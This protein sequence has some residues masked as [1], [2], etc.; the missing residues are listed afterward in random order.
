MAGLQRA[1]RR[2]NEFADVFEDEFDDDF[3]DTLPAPRRAPEQDNSPGT[4]PVSAVRPRI[5]TGPRGRT[6]IRRRPTDRATFWRVLAVSAAVLVVG[7][8]GLLA[9]HAMR[10]GTSADIPPQAATDDSAPAQLA[11]TAP[12]DA[13]RTVTAAA[14]PQAGDLQ[15]SARVAKVASI[16]TAPAVPAP[17]AE[18]PPQKALALTAAPAVPPAATEAGPTAAD[19]ARPAFIEPVTEDDEADMPDAATAPLPQP[20]PTQLASAEDATPRDADA[21]SARITM[22]VTLRSGPRRSAS[23]IGTLNEGTKVALYSCKSWC[24][25]SSGDKRGF[26]YRNAVGR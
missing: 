14:I 17:P 7:T 4:A 20:R 2:G 3:A 26:V 18:A 22:D 8:G 23:A 9:I 21:R 25:V 6:K 24:E 13:P 5:G 16:L 10:P 1:L 12:A 15:H 19:L 11:A